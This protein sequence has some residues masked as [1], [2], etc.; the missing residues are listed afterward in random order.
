MCFPKSLLKHRLEISDVKREIASGQEKTQVNEQSNSLLEHSSTP[1]SSDHIFCSNPGKRQKCTGTNFQN[2]TSRRKRNKENA[3]RARQKSREKLASL[4]YRLEYVKQE[5][6]S[7]IKLVEECRTAA[8]L[9]SLREEVLK[10]K[11]DDNSC[12]KLATV[13]EQENYCMKYSCNN[14]SDLRKLE[15]ELEADIKV[16][17]VS[18]SNGITW[19]ESCMTD[20][21]WKGKKISSEELKLYRSKRNQDRAKLARMRKKKYVAVLEKTVERFESENKSM[22]EVLAVPMFKLHHY[23]QNA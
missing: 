16:Q 6:E 11:K 4:Q 14:N 13:P 21:H 20:C 12:T 19:K 15:L 5:R 23:N 10:G 22:K 9:L 17:Q 7:L 8:V 18:K 3:R 1:E 2:E